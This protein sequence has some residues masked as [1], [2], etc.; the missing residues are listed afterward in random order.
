[1]RDGEGVAGEPRARGAVVEAHAERKENV[2]GARGVV[3]LV[4]AVAGD[5]PE[6]ERMMGVDRT[7]AARRPGDRNAQPLR[8]SQQVGGGAAVLDALADESDGP[9]GGE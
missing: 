7:R 2:G 6:G 9:L 1:R 4:G 5:E 8:E 3:G